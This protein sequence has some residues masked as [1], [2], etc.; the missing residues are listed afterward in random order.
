M[1]VYYLRSVEDCK[2]GGGVN[3]HPSTFMLQY[4]LYKFSF[5]PPQVVYKGTAKGR[6]VRCQRTCSMEP[7]LGCWLRCD[8]SGRALMADQPDPA[9]QYV[10]WPYSACPEGSSSE[11]LSS[12]SAVSPAGL[13][14][15]V[16]L[17][18]R[19]LRLGELFEL[20]SEMMGSSTKPSGT[21]D[22]QFF[23]I[24][25]HPSSSDDDAEDAKSRVIPLSAELMK[26]V[27]VARRPGRFR[28]SDLT[29]WN[30]RVRDL[31]SCAQPEH[32]AFVLN[33]VTL[34]LLFKLGALPEGVF[35]ET[36]QHETHKQRP[37]VKEEEEEDDEDEDDDD[38]DDDNEDDNEEERKEE[39]PSL[40]PMARARF[41][42]LNRRA[43]LNGQACVLTRLVG[44]RWAVHCPASDEKVTVLPDNLELL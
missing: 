11:F 15:T 2:C 17:D 13:V 27:L 23:P 35:H 8:D 38:E 6:G 43:D 36:H 12:V 5:K 14:A 39:S 30:H 28:P 9:V 22:T 20:E 16:R 10:P 33:Q 42:G 21:W 37:T 26:Q 31:I 41:V 19:F 7:T 3:I 18:G 1:R 25:V 34:P 29:D 32:E 40:Q 24:E 4:G 44:A